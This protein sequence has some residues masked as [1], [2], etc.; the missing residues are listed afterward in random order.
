M[1]VEAIR[2]Y[3]LGM[4][5]AKHQKMSYQRQSV[6]QMG[7]LVGDTVSF[8]SK[9]GT[10]AGVGA[11]LGLSAMGLISLL[12]G[13]AAAPI[14]Y[15]LYAVVG[16]VAGGLTGNALDKVEEEERSLKDA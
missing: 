13:G 9:V 1:R 15:G 6:P 3:G 4:P 7:A 16:S 8:K 14:A 5:V 2:N 10:G 11:M 12:S